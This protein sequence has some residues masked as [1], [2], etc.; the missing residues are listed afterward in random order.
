MTSSFVPRNSGYI[1]SNNPATPLTS[2]AVAFRDIIPPASH[3]KIAGIAAHDAL[4]WWQSRCEIPEP[5]WLINHLDAR[6]LKKPFKGF[7]VDGNLREM[8]ITTPSALLIEK[9][10]CTYSAPD[11]RCAQYQNSAEPRL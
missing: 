4:P 3:P 6:S 2:A 7:T 10:I 8:S 5:A 9:F 11:R 1:L